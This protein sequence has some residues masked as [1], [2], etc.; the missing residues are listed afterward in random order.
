[1]MLGHIPNH[2]T[3]AHSSSANLPFC[4]TWPFRVQ[5]W[6]LSEMKSWRER[7]KKAEREPTTTLASLLLFCKGKEIYTPTRSAHNKTRPKKKNTRQNQ[8]QHQAPPSS[9]LKHTHRPK[10]IVTPTSSYAARNGLSGEAWQPRLLSS[11]S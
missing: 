10:V 3:H 8:R 9:L 6:L 11:P 1:M 5:T 2:N 4:Q 7:G